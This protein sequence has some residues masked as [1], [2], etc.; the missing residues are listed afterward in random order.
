MDSPRL[1]RSAAACLA[2]NSFEADELSEDDGAVYLPRSNPAEA[3]P[4]PY[5]SPPVS[6]VD[7]DGGVGF[8]AGVTTAGVTGAAGAGARRSSGTFACADAP[9]SDLAVD[10]DG[11][12]GSNRLSGT[13]AFADAPTSD[14]AV[15]TDGGAGV[16]DAAVLAALSVSDIVA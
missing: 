9:T 1:P 14:L 7:T 11:G 12:A 5:L 2:R 13:F 8:A 6:A 16:A 15:D 3:L 10:T 4:E